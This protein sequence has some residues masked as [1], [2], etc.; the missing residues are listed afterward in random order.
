VTIIVANNI[1]EAF[2]RRVECN[3]ARVCLLRK[4]VDSWMSLSWREVEERVFDI[5]QVLRRH[6]VGKGD[7][8]A[9]LAHNQPAWAMS[10]YAILSLGAVTVPIYP[11]LMADDVFYILKDSG[12]K[13]LIVDNDTQVTKVA[14]VRDKL[15]DLKNILC[16][17]STEDSRTLFLDREILDERAKLSSI[18]DALNEW[19]SIAQGIKREDVASIVYTSGTTGEPKGAVLTHGNFLSIA[20]Q[21]LSVMDLGENDVSLFFLPPAHVLGRIEQFLSM[22]AGW[23]TAYCEDLHRFVDNLKE[24]KP[25]FFITVPRIFEKIFETISSRFQ[26]G[27]PFGSFIFQ[28]AMHVAFEYSRH[29]ELKEKPGILLQKQFD[30][31]NAILYSKVKRRFGERFRFAIVGGAMMSEALLRFFHTCGILV[32]E[33]YGLTESTGP[34]ALNTPRHFRLGTV[35]RLFFHNRIKIETDGEILLKGPTIFTKYL[36]KDTE[37]KEAFP[38]DGFFATGDVGH[39]DFEGYLKITDRKKDLIVSSGGKKISPQ[40]VEKVITED[41]LF[42]QAL[43]VGDESHPLGVLLAIN[44][45]EA[46]K[47][48]RESKS[49]ATL[50]YD[51]WYKGIPFREIVDERLKRSIEKLASFERPRKWRL[52]PRDLSIEAGELTPSLKIRRKFCMQKFAPIIQEMLG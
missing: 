14:S 52:L 5:A 15:P 1:A 8:V 13:L 4:Q 3:P 28:H 38:A 46:R 16:F 29:L 24:V 22:I 12:A 7:R 33:G 34:V 48:Y 40:K 37:T 26:T 41:T 43:V 47:I 32:L 27:L 51:D 17:N 50:S 10:D 19:R 49:A 31:Y 23:T 20:D 30:L 42:S 2:H 35:G 44:L 11:T 21:G 25:T 18:T 6:G 39:V 9:L 45:A 36:G